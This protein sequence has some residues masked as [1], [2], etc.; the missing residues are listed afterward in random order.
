MSAHLLANAK[1]YCA[2]VGAIATGLLG[3]YGPETP[4]GQ[5]LV[6]ILAVTTAVVTFR[7]PNTPRDSQ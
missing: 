6:V 3:V 5:V 1:A 2:L 7:V 4:V